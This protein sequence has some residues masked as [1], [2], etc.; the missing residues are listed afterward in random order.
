MKNTSL[1]TH[2]T[3]ILVRSLTVN[4]KK[5]RK[6]RQKNMSGTCQGT[7]LESLESLN[8]IYPR[9]FHSVV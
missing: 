7:N 2:S 5:K 3:N 4:V 6:K 8:N 1:F 9:S